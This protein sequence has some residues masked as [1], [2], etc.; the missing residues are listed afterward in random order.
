MFMLA[1]MLAID[2]VLAVYIWILV[3]VAV[4][5]WLRAFNV[6]SPNNRAINMLGAA[7]AAVTEFALRPLRKVLPDLSGVDISPLVLIGVLFTFR[8]VL[9]IYVFPKL[10]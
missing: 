7:L 10:R 6:V 1:V 3:G 9:A 4:I 2:F 5:Y 8:Y